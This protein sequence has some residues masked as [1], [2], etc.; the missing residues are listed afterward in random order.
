MKFRY[1][2]V[3]VMIIALAG[4]LPFLASTALANIA[5]IRTERAVAG[6][7]NSHERARPCISWYPSV[8]SARSAELG[9]ATTLFH[10]A[11]DIDPANRVLWSALGRNELLRNDRA[12]AAKAF[13]RGSGDPLTV[14]LLGTTTANPAVL[15]SIPGFGAGVMEIG[16]REERAGS[17]ESALACYEIAT[18]VHPQDGQAWLATGKAL[19]LSRRS[20][21]AVRALDAAISHLATAESVGLA[22]AYRAEAETQMGDFERARRDCATAVV[23]AHRSWDVQ[24]LCG[25]TLLTTGAPVP[26]SRLWKSAIAID[27]A[28]PE[29]YEQLAGVQ[30]SGKAYRDAED[31]CRRLE[32]VS[33]WRGRRCAAHVLVSEGKCDEAIPLLRG[34][35]AARP[36]DLGAS[37][38]MRTCNG[39]GGLR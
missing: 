32:G 30:A 11:V 35:L 4:Y 13:S 14:L 31:T 18:T 12:D 34:L 25:N 27:P 8:D 7:V 24:F 26:A 1:V 15:R 5:S 39:T 28:R 29:P 6:G 22:Q 20:H 9:D 21:D 16:R 33:P 3:A 10:R 23:A 2:V 17:S 36:N 37:D 38:M 19:A